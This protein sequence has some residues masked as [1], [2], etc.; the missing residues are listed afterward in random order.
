MSSIGSGAL[1]VLRAPRISAA[2]AEYNINDNNRR[3]TVGAF[4]PNPFEI[5]LWGML[6]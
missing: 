6:E 4:A 5:D 3:L 1:S 2:D